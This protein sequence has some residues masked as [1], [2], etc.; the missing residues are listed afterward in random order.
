MMDEG[1]PDIR[2][3]LRF[4]ALSLGH[5]V[6]K[7]LFCPNTFVRCGVP[8]TPILFR[9]ASLLLYGLCSST[10]CSFEPLL[11]DKAIRGNCNKHYLV[12]F[13]MVCGLTMAL[14]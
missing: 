9:V 6:V 1:K 14:H 7:P 13:T 11:L 12:V 3:F 4:I 10:P 8:P 2:D 5:H